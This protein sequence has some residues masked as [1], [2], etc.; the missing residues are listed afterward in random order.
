MNESESEDMDSTSVPDGPETTPPTE[1]PEVREDDKV[2]ALGFVPERSESEE[3]LAASPDDPDDRDVRV[4]RDEHDVWAE[5]S[6]AFEV[7]EAP[8]HPED[9]PA[10]EIDM[11]ALEAVGA[12]VSESSEGFSSDS[13]PEHLPTEAA[14][15]TPPP[16]P[17]AS[18]PVAVQATNSLLQALEAHA[19]T[20][21]VLTVKPQTSFVQFLEP[22]TGHKVYVSRTSREGTPVRV[23]TTLPLVGHLPGATAPPKENGKIE[24]VLSPDVETCIRVLDLLAGKSF[25]PVRPPR[26][27]APAESTKTGS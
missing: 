11:A 17:V 16:P 5:P 21:G 15:A 6:E 1:V 24:A 22:T 7:T 19:Q 18:T 2:Y 27:P 23:E 25:G 13:V 8:P 20:L 12:S 14:E 10:E 3:M 26:R 4:P 9:G